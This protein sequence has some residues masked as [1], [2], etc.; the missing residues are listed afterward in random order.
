ML[1]FKYFILFAEFVRTQCDSTKELNKSPEKMDQKT[2]MITCI[3]ASNMFKLRIRFG[4]KAYSST[5]SA[6][7]YLFWHEC[8]LPTEDDG[9]SSLDIP[10]S[11]AHTPMNRFGQIA[12]LIEINLLATN[13]ISY[14]MQML[15][16]MRVS[17]K[18]NAQSQTII[19]PA[20]NS[21]GVV[22]NSCLFN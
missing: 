6:R 20:Y 12:G 16:R 21:S 22:T 2:V 10:L 5:S 11:G 3:Y 14:Y 1:T 7:F 17:T 13:A 8:E 4:A 18:R 19:G 9:E 15:R